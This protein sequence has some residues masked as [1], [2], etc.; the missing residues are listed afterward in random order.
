M[1]DSREP[2]QIE[3]RTKGCSEKEGPNV[4]IGKSTNYVELIGMF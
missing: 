2:G 3:L 1:A 4:L